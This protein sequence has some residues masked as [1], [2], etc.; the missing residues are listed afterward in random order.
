MFAFGP[1]AGFFGNA[2]YVICLLFYSPVI[3][4]ACYL[5][6]P[7]ISQVIGYWIGIDRLPGWGTWVGTSVILVGILFIQLADR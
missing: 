3:V 1:A 5:L 4:S 2:G 7:F 6:E